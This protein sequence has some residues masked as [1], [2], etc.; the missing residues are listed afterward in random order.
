MSSS[1]T[2]LPTKIQHWHTGTLMRLCPE[3]KYPHVV[4]CCVMLR[5]SLSHRWLEVTLLEHYLPFNHKKL[6]FPH[7]IHLMHA[8]K[9]LPVGI[10]KGHLHRAFCYLNWKWTPDSH[11]LKVFTN[12]AKD[13]TTHRKGTE[14]WTTTYKPSGFCFFSKE[15]SQVTALAASLNFCSR[16]W[17]PHQ[18]RPNMPLQSA[19]DLG[20]T[21]I[22]MKEI[23][24]RDCKLS[25]S[26][27]ATDFVVFVSP[28]PC[29]ETK[30]KNIVRRLWQSIHSIIS[31]ILG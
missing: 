4:T 31:P 7:M 23:N 9:H 15:K 8:N 20:S 6:T 11:W 2:L 10:I 26:M 5:N 13:K 28:F 30:E 14:L 17:H 21:T 27:T 25:C 29:L 19:K 1:H 16:R 22:W 18:T 3:R 24:Q 12:P